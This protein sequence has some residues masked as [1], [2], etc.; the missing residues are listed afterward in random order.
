MNNALEIRNITKKYKDFTLGEINLEIPKGFATALIGANG[1][2]KTTL[3]DIICG[4]SGSSGGEISYFGKYSDPDSTEVKNAIGYC[5]AAG[6]FPADWTAKKVRKALSLGFDNFS[7]EKFDE[8][9]KIFDI[10]NGTEKKPKAVYT[11]SDG[12]KMR[13]YLASAFSRATDMLVLDEPGS[14]LDPLMRDTLCDLFRRYLSERDGERTILFSTHNIADMEFA[15]DYAVFM[16]GGKVIESGFVEELKEKYIIVNG[17]SD[18]FN[19]ARPMMIT[20]QRNNTVFEGLAL[21]EN[22]NT[23]EALDCAVEIPNL[24]QLSVGILKKAQG[25]GL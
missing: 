1:A 24:Q 7:E 23:L 25:A 21:S 19:N 4:I 11:L 10:G 2:G 17:S 3:L 16:H 8:Y 13:L 9:C 22:R 5:G 18:N 20:A 14:S 6:F 15:T 12:N